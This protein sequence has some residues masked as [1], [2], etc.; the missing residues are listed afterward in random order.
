M[1]QLIENIIDRHTEG[2]YLLSSSDK[3]NIVREMID[4]VGFIGRLSFEEIE[5]LVK[6]KHY[7]D[8]DYGNNKKQ[9]EELI[10]ATRNKVGYTSDDVNAYL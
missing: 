10:E 7:N 2:K 5:S 4:L 1:K 3:E 9:C 6:L 8:S